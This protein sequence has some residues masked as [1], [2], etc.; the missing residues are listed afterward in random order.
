MTK[1]HLY[2][3]AAGL[4]FLVAAAF[5]AGLLACL[6]LFIGWVLSLV[7]PFSTLL[8][9]LMFLIL[10]WWNRDAIAQ[11]GQRVRQEVRNG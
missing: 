6:C 2:D 9:T 4:L 7:L 8:W 3:L 11:I 5:G 10:G 1:D